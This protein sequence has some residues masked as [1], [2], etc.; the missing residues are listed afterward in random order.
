MFYIVQLEKKKH[1][2]TKMFNKKNC[3]PFIKKKT[4]SLQ[5]TSVLPYISNKAAGFKTSMV[6]D[7]FL[8]RFY[9]RETSLGFNSVFQTLYLLSKLVLNQF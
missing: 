2:K 7:C 4:N 6:S 9:R 8:W 3:I 5:D 1:I